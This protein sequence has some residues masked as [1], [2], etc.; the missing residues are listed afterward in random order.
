MATYKG[1]IRYRYKCQHMNGNKKCLNP[2][3]EATAEWCKNHPEKTGGQMLCF[4]H[5]ADYLKKVL[6]SWIGPS[7]QSGTKV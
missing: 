6:Q 5:Q 1:D 2:I 4:E 3:G 7:E